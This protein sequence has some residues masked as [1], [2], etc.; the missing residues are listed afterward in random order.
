MCVAVLF[1]YVSDRI[2]C[3]SLFSNSF[4]L[5]SG[6]RKFDVKVQRFNLLK[7]LYYWI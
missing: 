6:L 4:S 5:S 1:G 7:E 2:L 3:V